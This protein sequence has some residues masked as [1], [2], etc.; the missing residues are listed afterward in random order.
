MML[1]RGSWTVYGV[2]KKLTPS[3]TNGI[4]VYTDRS[5]I[6]CLSIACCETCS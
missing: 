1:L 6:L 5:D 4:G 2:L 3:E